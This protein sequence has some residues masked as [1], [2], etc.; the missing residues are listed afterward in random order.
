MSHQSRVVAL[1]SRLEQIAALSE[2][3]DGIFRPFA[4]PSAEACVQLVGEWCRDAHLSMRKDAI[5]N[6]RIHDPN[7]SGAKRKFFMGSHVDTVIN[8]GKYDG[9]LGFLMALDQLEQKRDCPFDLEVVGFSDE[10]GVRYGTAYL[11][12]SVLVGNFDRDLLS[13]M[14][15]LG[16]S[17]SQAISD[18]GGDPCA[19]DKACFGTE[20]EFEGYLEVHLEQGPVLAASQVPVGVV[21]A[22]AGQFRCTLC[23]QGKE[24]HAGTVPMD[25]RKDAG[26]G[27]AEFAMSLERYALSRSHEMVA[28]MGKWTVN[29]NASNVI[30]SEAKVSVDLR[31]SN[32]SALSQGIEFIKHTGTEIAEKRGLAFSLRVDQMNPSVPMSDELKM[33]LATA[34]ASTGQPPIETRSGAGHDA[35]ILSHLGPVAMLFVRCREGI[36]HSPEEYVSSED[37]EVAMKVCDHFFEHY[38]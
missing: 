7:R 10:E 36:S 33:R 15:D 25:H 18:F 8:A 22:I 29:P 16:I 2:T 12:S 31:S 17:M 4:S 37:I 35:A 38:E 11:G 26:L 14:D 21:T 28:T 6:I 19:L 24:G 23:F 1:S 13:K 9:V 30:P 34:I 3:P 5:G 27:A 20:N 32:E